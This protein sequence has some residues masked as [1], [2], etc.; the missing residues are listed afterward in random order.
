VKKIWIISFVLAALGAYAQAQ[1]PKPSLFPF[2]K[3]PTPTYLKSQ[4]QVLDKFNSDSLNY[5]YQ[6]SYFFPEQNVKLVLASSLESELTG[7][8]IFKNGTV[9]GNQTYKFL[10]QNIDCPEFAEAADLNGDGNIDFIVRLK[11][12]N[13]SPLAQQ[14]HTNFY[15]FQKPE[16]S[17]YFVN[18]IGSIFPWKEYD[19][20][21][22]G[23]YEAI[24]VDLVGI[25]GQNVFN[26]NVFSYNSEKNIW[27]N[28][29]KDLDYPK[30]YKYTPEKGV[31]PLRK[32]KVKKATVP[33]YRTSM[34]F[35]SFREK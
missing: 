12:N 31:W 7:L 1:P 13:G 33:F 26:L 21:E 29:G 27:L 2:L 18:I 17:T 24:N 16:R 25:A 32:R 4:K 14:V 22:D 10:S 11:N 3:K 20:N 35:V 30:F 9:A 5:S 28:V 23:K 8:T 34:P 6:I 19:L 15:V